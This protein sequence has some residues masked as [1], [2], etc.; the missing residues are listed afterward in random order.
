MRAIF[1]LIVSGFWQGVGVEFSFF[2]LWIGWQLL[3]KR[4]GHLFDP[5]HFFHQVH[6]YFK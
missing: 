4:V 1:Q 2:I 3:H 6:E 5:E